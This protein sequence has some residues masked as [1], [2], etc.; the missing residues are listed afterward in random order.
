M[1][2]LRRKACCLVFCRSFLPDAARVR[3]H[4]AEEALEEL[5]APLG[6]CSQSEGEKA[7]KPERAKTG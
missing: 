2:A 4:H 3:E 5:H 7:K 6:A 1:S